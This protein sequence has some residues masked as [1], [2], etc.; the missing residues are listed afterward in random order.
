MTP[1][2]DTNR[3][4]SSRSPNQHPLSQRT[5]SANSGELEVTPG[6]T[7]YSPNYKSNLKK[8]PGYAV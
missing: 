6:C 2:M 5:L 7:D 3:A 1:R 8:E 4:A